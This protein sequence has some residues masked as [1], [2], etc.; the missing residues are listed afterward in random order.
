MKDA[1][2]GGDGALTYYRPDDEKSQ[3]LAL[4]FSAISRISCFEID[5]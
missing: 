2:N 1:I 3:P 5:R 4:V